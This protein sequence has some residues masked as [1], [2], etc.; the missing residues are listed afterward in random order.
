VRCRVWLLAED[1]DNALR[2]SVR[3]EGPGL[4]DDRIRYLESHDDDTAPR[5]ERGGLGLWIVRRLVSEVCGRL[6]VTKPP[7]GGTIITLITPKYTDK[8][9]RHVA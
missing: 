8:D 9:L 1:L 6:T 5:A 7:T 4:D 2:I 3:D